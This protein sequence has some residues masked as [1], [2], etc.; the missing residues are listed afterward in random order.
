MWAR[1]HV[2]YPLASDAVLL[3]AALGLLALVTLP[4]LVRGLGRQLG[5]S[6]AAPG[7]AGIVY[8]VVYWRIDVPP[9]FWYYGL[10]I[11]GLT[12]PLAFAIAI[13]SR[14]A[15]GPGR[16]L[17]S[18]TL[19]GVLTAVVLVRVVLTWGHGLSTSA[20]LRE[21]PVH[22][23]AAL[24]SQYEQLGLDLPH[25]IGP[26]ATVRS[27]GEFGTMLYYCNCRL[28]DRFN[29][30]ALIM[31]RLLAAR[32]SSWLMRLNYLWLD[33]SR[34]PTVQ[35]DYHLFYGPGHRDRKGGW[36]V[37]SPTRGDGHF[38]LRPG[39]SPDDLRHGLAP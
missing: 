30:R 19:A 5:L 25:R 3:I 34:Y 10:P 24:P 23:N 12:L 7:V 29:E 9:Y 18:R 37:W 15:V 31:G 8:F 16:I 35:Q 28:L 17:Q 21:A 39:P 33:P 27:A 26:H 32:R 1:Y 36:N 38:D 6:V 11:A 2:L 13:L 20:P 14:R 22:G 4:F